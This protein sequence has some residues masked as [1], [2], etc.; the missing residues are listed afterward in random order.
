MPMRAAPLRE[1]ARHDGGDRADR[2]VQVRL[3]QVARLAVGELP[4]AELLVGAGDDQHEVDASRGRDPVP[5]FTDV[6]RFR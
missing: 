2:T 3:E 5:R 1:Q 6:L 4:C